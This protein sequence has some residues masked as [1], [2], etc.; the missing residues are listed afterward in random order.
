VGEEP[1]ISLFRNVPD[2]VVKAGVF[3][4]ESQDKIFD[5]AV[6]SGLRMI[7]LHGNESPEFCASLKSS[8]LIIVKSFNIDENF[9]LDGIRSYLKH[10]DYF[11]FDAKSEKFGGS[12]KKFGWN[13][14]DG[15]HLEKPFFL[16]GG[17]GPEDAGLINKIDN[18]GLFAVDINSRFEISP[19]I[20]DVAMV[21]GFIDTIKK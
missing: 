12:G 6:K 16:S 2:E 9:D 4:N 10:C 14:L 15:Y 21:K 3:V 17:I 11:L 1:D 7:Q 5:T 13:K 19:G 20:K 8:G 18:R